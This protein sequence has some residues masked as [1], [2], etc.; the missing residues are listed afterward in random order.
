MGAHGPRQQREERG[1]GSGKKGGAGEQVAEKTS[2]GHC[3]A[4]QVTGGFEAEDEDDGGQRGEASHHSDSDHTVRPCSTGY[5]THGVSTEYWVLQ[6]FPGYHQTSAAGSWDHLYGLRRPS[7]NNRHRS[8]WSRSQPLLPLHRRHHLHH[9]SHL[10]L[11]LSAPSEGHNKG[12]TAVHL[13]VD[14]GD[15]HPAGDGVLHRR[16]DRGP[17]RVRLV[18]HQPQEK[19]HHL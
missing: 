16:L 2:V 4:L 13:H 6:V 18:P 9:H 5:T 17:V 8:L 14:G 12:E 11:L 10:D 15:L 19:Q 1:G 7:S 3:I